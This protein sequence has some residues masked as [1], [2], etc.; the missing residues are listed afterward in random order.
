MGQGERC[1]ELANSRCE[2]Q[3]CYLLKQETFAPLPSPP[4]HHQPW[5]QRGCA[6][7]VVQGLFSALKAALPP[8][9]WTVCLP[10]SLQW[11]GLCPLAPFSSP[12]AKG[13]K[14][15]NICSFPIQVLMGYGK[16]SY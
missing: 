5:T 10:G 13:F 7:A 2:F 3:R 4:P 12:S 8:H 6:G 14:G 9:Q 1:L 11:D 16:G 15:V